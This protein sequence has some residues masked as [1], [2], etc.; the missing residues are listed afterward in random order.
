M[1]L[2]D[3]YLHPEI[4]ASHKSRSKRQPVSQL[5]INLQAADK[6]KRVLDVSNVVAYF[7]MDPKLAPSHVIRSW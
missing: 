3:K 4:K 5:S 2:I 7:L 6:N 1:K